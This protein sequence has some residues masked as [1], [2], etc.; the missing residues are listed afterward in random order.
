MGKEAKRE[1]VFLVDDNPSNLRVGK[2]VLSD[3]YK[4]YTA[5]SAENMFSLLGE[6]QPALI[7]LDVDMP[8]MDGYGAI[9]ILKSK[10]ET[11]DIPVIFLTAK[12]D[13]ENEL[14]GLELG[15]VDYITK[16]FVPALLLKRIKVHLL[17]EIQKNELYQFNHNLKQ[18]VEEKTG[19]VLK[20]QEAILETVSDLVESRDHVTGGHVERTQYIL[21]VMLEALQRS[22][23]YR[24]EWADW[25]IKL[26]LQSSQLHDVGKISISDVI[27]NKPAPLTAEEFEDMKKHPV[28]GGEIIEKIER[29]ATKSDFLSYA[30]TFALTHHEK[31]DGSGYPAGLAGTDIPL[32]GRLMAITDVYDALTSVRPY[33]KALSPDEAAQIILAGKGTHFDPVLVDLFMEEHKKF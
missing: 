33:K 7:L 13:T 6:I 28:I 5:S 14:K 31:W 23:V 30:K 3:L 1:I 32:L 22:S 2:N 11:M 4:V 12:A 10:P 8:E 16:P 29:R 24:E 20:L 18:R 25:D 27:L 19:E 21:K 15:A 17:V 26:L 9:K